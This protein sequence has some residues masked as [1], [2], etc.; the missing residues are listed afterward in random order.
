MNDIKHEILSIFYKNGIINRFTIIKSNFRKN[1]INLYNIIIDYNTKINCNSEK[2]SQFIYNFIN[3]ITEL[4]KCKI[5]ENNV[6]FKSFKS[7]YNIYC[8]TKCQMLCKDNTKLR[9]KTRLKK[10]NGKYI[11]IEKIKKSNLEKYGIEWY[12]NREK[13]MKTCNIKYGGNAPICSPEIKEKIKN[14]C[15]EKYNSTSPLK[16]DIILKKI[17]DTNLRKYNTIMYISTKEFKEKSKK[18]KLEKYGDENYIN[19]EQG[20]QTRKEKYGSEYYLGT[21]ECLDKTRKHNLKKYEVEYY[22]QTEEFKI[23][24]KETCIKKYNTIYYLQSSDYKIK[25]RNTS[26]LKYNVEHPTQDKNI[27][28]KQQLSGLKLKYYKNTNLYYRG[29]YEYKFLELCESLKIL[30]NIRNGPNIK[31]IFDDKN[32]IYFSDFYYKP[33]NLVIEIKSWWTYYGNNINYFFNKNQAKKKYSIKNGYDFMF[34]ID[35]D[36]NDLINK[37]N[38]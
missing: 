9:I 34:I 22:L 23:K 29:S 7:G 11:D 38:K 26:L 17:E 31:Y 18:S 8:S 5:C 33:L 27:H 36:F 20:K 21:E 30:N 15:I 24:S 10:N 1:H 19:N 4:P 3:D 12:T 25:N 37:L 28:D 32:K 13:F 14:T 2:W 35:N 16:S 6:N